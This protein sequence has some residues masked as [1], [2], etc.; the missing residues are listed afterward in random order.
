MTGVLGCALLCAFPVNS[1]AALV[2][3]FSARLTDVK[4][5][6]GAYTVVADARAYETSGAPPPILTQA[7]VHFP[8]GAGLR[9]TFLRD[10]FYCDRV[11]LERYPPDPARCRSS[12]FASGTIVLDAR[13]HIDTPFSADIHL[14]LAKGGP[15]ALASVTVLVIPNEF[16]PVY[17]YQVLEG[18]LIDESATSGRFGYR[19]ELPTYVK[20]LIPGLFLHLAEIHLNIRGLRL[21]RRG[22]APLFWTKVPSCPRSRKVSFGADYS[23]E[24]G[25]V[26]RKRRRVD[27]RRFVKRPTV[28]REGQIPGAPG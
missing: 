18:R 19:L 28:Q 17:A 12:H 16:T 27:C 15:G 5:S 21:E 13:P 24:G 9:S 23:F 8:R 20:P 11:R 10:E 3:E 1:H 4:R 25:A 22:R 2:G 6:N 26:I 7:V 14:F